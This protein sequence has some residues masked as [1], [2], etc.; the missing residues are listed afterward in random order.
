MSLIGDWAKVRDKLQHLSDDL[1]AEIG[2]S[3]AKS[4]A[5]IERCAVGHINKQ[6]L[7]L[8]PLSP[9]YAAYKARTRNKTWRRRR[10]KAGKEN[11][12]SLSEKILVAT[13]A[14]RQSITNYQTGPFSGEVGVSRQESYAD[15]EKIANIGIM[16]S[17]GTKNMPARDIW[18]PTAKEMAPK[19][20]EN[21]LSAA[22][23]VLYA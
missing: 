7:D 17:T 8:A 13:G 5:Q 18:E 4:L 12:R 3:T 11:P 22:R 14:F 20:T 16:L 9:K 23:K 15:G 1:K 21:F 2:H 10:S 19:V 6:D